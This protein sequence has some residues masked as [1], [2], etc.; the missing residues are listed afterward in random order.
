[1]KNVAWNELTM[2]CHGCALACLLGLGG[3]AGT[4]TGNAGVARLEAGL[5]TTDDSSPDE[6]YTTEDSDGTSFT[7]ASAR[8]YVRDIELDLPDQV[9]CD[10][11]RDQLEGAG[12]RCEDSDD[13]ASGDDSPS[14]GKIKIAGPYVVNLISREATPS[15]A[16]VRIPAMTY[17]RVD[18]RLDDA[19][20]DLA[21]DAELRGNTLV[22][23]GSY[24]SDSGTSPFRLALAFSED[25]RFESSAGV[26]VTGEGATLLLGLEVESWFSALPIGACAE[27]GDLAF[28][29]DTLVIGD[30]DG[31]CSDIENELKDAIKNATRLDKR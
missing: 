23:S 6:T 1:M 21:G 5:V 12:V 29:G 10:D 24:V 22:A 31:G 7:L 3:C 8:A 19:P 15:L 4:D 26:A 16:D 20:D 2:W 28:D 30:G 25:A 27:D 14:G 17:R 18:V 13:T 11:V 9:T